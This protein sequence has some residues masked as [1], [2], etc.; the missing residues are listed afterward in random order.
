MAGVD[1]RSFIVAVPAYEFFGMILVCMVLFSLVY[2][3]MLPMVE[4]MEAV[5]MK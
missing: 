2:L 1:I 3:M 4:S 5:M